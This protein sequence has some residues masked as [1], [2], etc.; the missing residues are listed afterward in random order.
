MNQCRPEK[1]DTKKPSKT[2]LKLE[3]VEVPDRNAEGWKVGE[4]E[5]SHKK[6]CKMLRE[7][8]EVGGF[9]MAQKGLW[10]IAKKRI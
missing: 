2:I 4:E 7:K 1:K 8:F 10:N 3:K 9:F 5:R 6:E